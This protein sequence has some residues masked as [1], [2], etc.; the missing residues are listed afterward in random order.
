MLTFSRPHSLR[1]PVALCAAGTKKIVEEYYNTIITALHFIS[2]REDSIDDDIPSDA[3]LAFFV[4]EVHLYFFLH[5]FLPSFLIY[6]DHI[7]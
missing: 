5:P 7:H 6:D 2:Y 3:K 1:S 4:R